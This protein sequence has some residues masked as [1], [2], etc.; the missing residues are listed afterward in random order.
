MA[1]FHHSTQTIGR[2]SGRSV[3]AAAAY[4]MGVSLVDERTGL[5]HSYSHK[6]GVDSVQILAPDNAPSWVM[7]A[8]KLWNEVE[9][10]EVRKDAQLCREINVALPVELTK[11]QMKELASSYAKE[12]WTDRGMIVMLAFHDLDSSNPHFHAMLTMRE[13]KEDGFGNKNRDWNDHS[14]ATIYRKNWADAVNERLEKY[15]HSARIDHRSLEEQGIDRAPQQHQG[16]HATA[17]ERKGIIVDR[18]KII[19]PVPAAMDH[20]QAKKDLE[21]RQQQQ[22]QHQLDDEKKYLVEVDKLFV[23]TKFGVQETTAS[24]VAGE[25]EVAAIKAS[26]KANEGSCKRRQGRVDDAEKALKQE[27]KRIFSA[28]FKTKRHKEA[29]KLHTAHL[30]SLERAKDEGKNYKEELKQAEQH[31]NQAKTEAD[32]AKELHRTVVVEKKDCEKKIAVLQK[33]I[34]QQSAPKI[35]QTY[36][37]NLHQSLEERRKNQQQQQ[38]K[39]PNQGPVRGM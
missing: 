3:V 7:D 38:Q 32:K 33:M 2:A 29:E 26:I 9:K 27:K 36:Q 31:Y 18:K 34:N 14:L 17:M 21:K 24:L 23:S 35:E 10:G 20:E 1:I 4:R 22:R 37:K 15:G 6:Q 25:K 5:T 8:N 11:E 30:A 19:L 13:I 12:Q 39:R 16:P 28:L